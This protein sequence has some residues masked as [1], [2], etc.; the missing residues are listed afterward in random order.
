MRILKLSQLRKEMVLVDVRSPLEFLKGHIQDSWNLPHAS[1]LTAKSLGVLEL[2]FLY[3]PTTVDVV[4]YCRLSL[5]R[6]PEALNHFQHLLNTCPGHNISQLYLLE[7]GFK[8]WESAKRP[9]VKG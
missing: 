6:G 9:I 1:L 3:T 2:P 4:I 8:G 7:G 5:I